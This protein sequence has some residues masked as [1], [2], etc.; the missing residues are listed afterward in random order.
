MKG[1]WVE[2]SCGIEHHVP[3]NRVEQ[4]QIELIKK[5]KKKKIWHDEYK[6][7]DGKEMRLES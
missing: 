7:Q 3:R 2:Y 4:R 6:M 1:K 5:P